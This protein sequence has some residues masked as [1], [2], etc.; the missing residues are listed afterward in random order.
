MKV[1]I[2]TSGGDSCGMNAAIYAVFNKCEELGIKLLGVRHGYKG[3][4]LNDIITL[5]RKEVKENFNKGG[6]F[7]KTARSAEFA[8]AEGVKRAKLV[9][10]N[11]KIDVLIVIGGNGSLRGC[12]DLQKEGVNCLFLPAT[13][14]N[15][16]GYTKF[17]IGFHTAVDNAVDA[18]NKIKQTMKTNDRGLICE[19]MGRKCYDIGVEC[20]IATRADLLITKRQPISKIVSKIQ[21]MVKMGNKSPHI[22]VQEYLLDIE[23]LAQMCQEATGKEFRSTVIGYLQRGGNPTPQEIIRATQMGAR[24]VNL[25]QKEKLNRAVGIINGEVIDVS[26]KTAIITPNT[27]EDKLIKL[28]N[29]I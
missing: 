27:P 13:I 20:A 7:L 26:L 23:A 10:E 29:H 11:N 24:A 18:I 5:D 15:D 9:L 22:I 2:L 6:S 12:Y 8:T 19:T 17:S 28:V 3:L 16:L 21:E 14:D 4:L 25:I 1:A